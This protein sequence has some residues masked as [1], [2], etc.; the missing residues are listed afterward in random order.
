MFMHSINSAGG[1]YL[2]CNLAIRRQALDAVGGFDE[3]YPHPH[4]EDLDLCYRVMKTVGAI[5]YEPDALVLHGVFPVGPWFF[6]RRVRYDPSGYRLF[7]L[8]PEIFARSAGMLP[9]PLVSGATRNGD[10]RPTFLQILAYHVV[11]RGM[12]ALSSL[13]RGVSI[14][15]RVLGAI[16]HAACAALSIYQAPACLGEYRRACWSISSRFLIEP[17]RCAKCSEYCTSLPMTGWPAGAWP[18]APW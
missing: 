3:T 4:C 6:L 8:H 17:T 16:T 15:E 11:C 7:A 14:R 1:Q 10:H 18:L 2:S 5:G 13:R 9:V 12:R